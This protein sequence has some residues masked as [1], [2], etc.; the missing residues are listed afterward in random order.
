MYDTFVGVGALLCTKT[1]DAS[2]AEHA[3]R[4]ERK[5]AQ[6]DAEAVCMDT[7]YE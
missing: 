3:A 2:I 1:I 6:H 7:T 4:A 5:G